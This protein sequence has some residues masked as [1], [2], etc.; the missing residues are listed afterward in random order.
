MGNY[1]KILDAL[2]ILYEYD[3]ENDETETEA[4]SLWEKNFKKRDCVSNIIME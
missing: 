3:N 4:K 1:E 2:K